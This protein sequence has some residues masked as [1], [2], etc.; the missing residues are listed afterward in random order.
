M[1]VDLKQE[2]LEDPALLLLAVGPERVS[3]LRTAPGDDHPDQIDITLV[4]VA[5]QIEIDP[6]R[7]G[8]KFRRPEENWFKARGTISAGVAEGL[9]NKVKLTTRRAYGFRTFDAVKAAL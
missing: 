2:V 1:L 3:R 6:H 5:L 7:A 4:G 8:W 9:N